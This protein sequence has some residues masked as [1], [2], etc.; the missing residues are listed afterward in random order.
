MTIIPYR[1]LATI[2]ALLGLVG[3]AIVMAPP[4]ALAAGSV[5]LAGGKTIA[6]GTTVAVTVRVNTGSDAI[7]AVQIN[8]AYPD[9]YLEFQSIAGSST[10]PI[11]AA[12]TGGGGAVSISRGTPGLGVTGDQPVATVNFKA[13]AGVAAA[14]TVSLAAGSALVR[15]SDQVNILSGTAQTIITIKTPTPTATPKPTVKTTPVPTATPPATP[16]TIAS[17]KIAEIGLNTATITWST[18]RP[19]TSV[20]EY[21]LQDVYGLTASTEGLS[22]THKVVLTSALLTPGATYHYRIRSVDQFG[23]QVLGPDGTFATKGYV[24]KVTVVNASGQGQP[25]AKVEVLTASQP[26]VLTT[27]QQGVATFTDLPLGKISV[28]VTTADGMVT[29]STLETKADAADT[30]SVTT[31]KV[32]GS[33]QTLAPWA[34]AAITFGAIGVPLI[35]FSIIRFFLSRRLTNTPKSPPPAGQLADAALPAASASS[36]L[37]PV[38][39]GAIA[40]ASHLVLSPS[41]PASQPEE[42]EQASLGANEDQ[43]VPEPSLD[44]QTSSE[45]ESIMAQFDDPLPPVQAS[46]NPAVSTPASPAPDESNHVNDTEVLDINDLAKAPEPDVMIIPSPLGATSASSGTDIASDD[47]GPFGRTT[48]TKNPSQ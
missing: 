47:V 43:S 12:S 29:K 25:G 4:P 18:D 2:T 44:P 28:V 45:L 38:G 22:T 37:S 8:L 26:R 36:N 42:S 46:A 13:R 3:S 9:Q 34:L 16:P 21:G 19:T 35:I 39:S 41:S 17:P 33:N 7:N 24:N 11:E 14:A 23:N 20:V 10:F 48:E 30:P 1:R 32:A 15:G 6:P 40:P 5:T 27:D 31:I